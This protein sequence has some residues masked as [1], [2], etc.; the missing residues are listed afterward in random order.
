MKEPA[1][2]VSVV[3]SGHDVSDARLHREVAGLRREGLSVEVLGLGEAGAG[4]DGVAVRVWVRGSMIA[5][6]L[7][8]LTLPWRARG[9]VLLTLDPDVVPAALL[10]A[11]VRRRRLVCDV[12]ED[13]LALLADRGWVPR[14]LRGVLRAL[15][16]WCLALAGRADLTC[17][18]DE[19]VPPDADRCRARL[20][21][22]NLPDPALLPEPGPL[23]A[24]PPL[25]AVYVGDVRTTR[26][27]RDMVEAVAGAPGWEL[28]VVG[29]VIAE[30]EP[31]L[32]ARLERD[33]V[34]GRVHL[35]GR[36]P[37]RQAWQVAAGASV[38]MQL[39][40]STPAFEGAVPTKLYEY[41]ATGL[42]VLATPL[43]RVVPLVEASGAGVLAGDAD[44]AAEVLR[45]WSERPA[46]LL[47]R[48]SAA[49]AYAQ[50]TLLAHSPWDVLAG[51]VEEL[52]RARR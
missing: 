7:R 9:R 13:Y 16:A 46:D 4:P 30:D 39:L 27:L 19:H 52:A 51:R 48:R 42:A 25:R 41:L 45:G 23:P 14:L 26:G 22:L 11:R 38:G 18:A 35:H 15:A 31:W 36:M 1:P 12:H 47:A 37:P 5:R 8:A 6:L 50:A 34:A 21:V 17:V 44:A 10:V 40:H 24:V 33:D 20:V 32:R 28:D 49:T 43:P 29:P 3:T 2:D